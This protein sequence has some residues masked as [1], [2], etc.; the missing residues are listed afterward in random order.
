MSLVNS[1]YAFMHA[2]Y[3]LIQLIQKLILREALLHDAFELISMSTR[4]VPY[5]CNCAHLNKFPSFES[6]AAFSSSIFRPPL[7][8]QTCAVTYSHLF[9]GVF[10]AAKRG[11]TTS[12]AKMEDEVY[13]LRQRVRLLEGAPGLGTRE[14]VRKVSSKL[15]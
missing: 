1:M 6:E 12:T 4:N 5:S 10:M 7:S 2:A 15:T 11:S 8:I 13:L 9:T 14:R 3:P